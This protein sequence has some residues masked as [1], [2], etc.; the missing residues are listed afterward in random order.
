MLWRPDAAAGREWEK[1]SELKQIEGKGEVKEP[2]SQ[3]QTFKQL[4]DTLKTVLL[5]VRPAHYS[6]KN[7][8]KI[9]AMSEVTGGGDCGM[10]STICA[11]SKCAI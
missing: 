2:W 5:Q 8:K 11:E 4:T 6:C 3:L 1:S 7:T 10:G 9:V